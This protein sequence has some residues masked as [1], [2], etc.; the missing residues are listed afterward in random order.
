MKEKAEYPEN[1]DQWIVHFVCGKLSQAENISLREW[2]DSSDE[3][4][5]LFQKL[6]SEENFS[7][8]IVT[9][10]SWNEREGWKQVQ[11]KSLRRKTIRRIFRAGSAAIALLAIGLGGLLWL[12]PVHQRV[13]IV[14]DTTPQSGIRFSRS[15]G[16][17][18]RL[19]TLH[20]LALENMVIVSD[21][22]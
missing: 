10:A 6:I 7:R 19:D 5:V 15:S 4:E 22:R 12:S 21:N 20:T 1:L 2:R 9:L 18:Y 16:K 11:Q 8:E 14:Q 17:V 3:H 13:K